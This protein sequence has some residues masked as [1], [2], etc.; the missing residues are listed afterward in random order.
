[1]CFEIRNSFMGDFG[2][3]LKL[4]RQSFGP[5]AWTVLDYSMVFSSPSVKKFTA[6]V[7]GK[8]AGFAA[9]E[10]PSKN[11]PASLMTIAVC[12]EYRRMGIG[13]ALLE[14]CE[15]AFP[16]EDFSLYVDVDNEN[17]IRLYKKGGYRE[18]GM[19]PAYYMN[20]HDA[21]VMEKKR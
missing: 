11:S 14:K 17:A 21:L 8:F 6:T 9:A 5:D 19:I 18:T 12:P 4:D 3:A 15:Q 1:M 20:G 10:K 13:A 16:G 2:P 7:T